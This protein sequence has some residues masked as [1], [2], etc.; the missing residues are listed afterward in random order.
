MAPDVL[1]EVELDLLGVERYV[2]LLVPADTDV[3]F[4]SIPKDDGL[5]LVHFLHFSP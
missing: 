4:L 2:S 1:I 5:D 3:R